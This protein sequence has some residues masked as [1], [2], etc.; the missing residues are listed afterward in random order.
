[1]HCS[2]CI[3]FE[4][5]LNWS[6][7]ITFNYYFN[8][9]TR[10]AQIWVALDNYLDYFFQ[11]FLLGWLSTSIWIVPLR[12]LWLRFLLFGL[13]STSIW[14]NLLKFL[15]IIV[16][17]YFIVLWFHMLFLSCCMETT[18]AYFISLSSGSY[19]YISYHCKA[20][21]VW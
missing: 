11:F 17:Y 20:D 6:T 18:W 15:S 21:L 8:F 14:I 9:F 16:S 1:M 2:T 3:S 5:Y 13:L 7:Q 19:K 4:Y 12:L 10:I